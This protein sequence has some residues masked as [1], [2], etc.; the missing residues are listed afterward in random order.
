VLLIV[1]ETTQNQE[2]QLEKSVTEAQENKDSEP[3][4]EQPTPHTQQLAPLHQYTQHSPF[5]KNNTITEKK[6]QM[7]YEHKHFD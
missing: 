2:P 7:T 1:S 3:R 4:H 6:W 5:T